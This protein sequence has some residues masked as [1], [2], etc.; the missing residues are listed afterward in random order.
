MTPLFIALAGLLTLAT[1]AAII[2]PL[3]RGDARPTRHLAL[4]ILLLLPVATLLL[5]LHFGRPDGLQVAGPASEPPLAESQ[6]EAT[7]NLQGA[8]DGLRQRLQAEP[9][10]IEGWRLLGRAYKALEQF[11][12]A[13]D[14]LAE[15]NRRAPDNADVM[16]DYAESIALSN[17]DHRFDSQALRLLQSALSVSPDHPRARWFAG[18]AAYQHEDYAKAAE[19][20]EQL[21]AMLPP[22]AEIVPALTARIQESR[23]LAG[24]PPMQAPATV[25]ASPPLLKLRVELDPALQEKVSGSDTV[26]VFARAINGPPMPLAVH[27]LTVAQLPAD[28]DLGDA[29]SMLP[30]MKLSSQSRVTVMARVSF[31][32]QPVAQSG[33]LESSP[34]EVAID[35]GANDD[36]RQHTLRIDSIHP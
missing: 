22:E 17:P 24:M 21:L 6:A 15:A 29:D 12:A 35:A 14:A 33:D 9:D 4:G 3:V 11:D 2:L 20:W 27:R 7:A 5:Y 16:V 28:I 25:A 19:I 36:D 10:D 34:Q 30:S 18:V 8:V 1:C 13:R 23:Q 32:G 26:F 31:G